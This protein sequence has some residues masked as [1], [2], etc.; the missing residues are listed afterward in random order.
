[1]D[2]AGIGKIFLLYY[3][4]RKKGAALTVMNPRRSIEKLLQLVN[5]ATLI[6][7]V[8]QKPDRPSGEFKDPMALV[9]VH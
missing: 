9:P 3:S 8:Q 6:P 5:L 7:I 2:S 4:L 1:M